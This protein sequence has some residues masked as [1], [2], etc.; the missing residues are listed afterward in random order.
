[1]A[2]TETYFGMPVRAALED[3]VHEDF[4]AAGRGLDEIVKMVAASGGQQTDIPLFAYRLTALSQRAYGLNIWMLRLLKED[5]IGRSAPQEAAVAAATPGRHPQ[6]A[7]GDQGTAVRTL[8]RALVRAGQTVDIDGI[9]RQKT[10]LA[11]RAL[12]RAAGLDADGIVGPDTWAA[13]PAAP[14]PLLR[15]GS[16]GETVAALQRALTRHASGRWNITPR[17]VTG[18]FDH[19]T[20]EA[21]QAFQRWNGI[22]SDGLV[23][24]QTWTA[25][26][27]NTGTS[28]EAAVARERPTGDVMR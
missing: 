7:I 8:Q 18:I 12:Q 22:A 9:F 24:H 16:K 5:K 15:P 26:V 6:L 3:Q 11:V 17:A 2:L 27:D 25:V 19:T 13:L 4:A 10:W 20:S 14:M 1:M 21:V 23:G 28:L